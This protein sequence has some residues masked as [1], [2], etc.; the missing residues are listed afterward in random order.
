MNDAPSIAARLRTIAQTA[1]NSHLTAEADELYRL[2]F[3]VETEIR[4]LSRMAREASLADIH[5]VQKDFK[6][7]GEL[8]VR[9]EDDVLQ[10]ILAIEALDFEV[11]RRV[12]DHARETNPFDA[13]AA[14]WRGHLHFL[15]R[16]FP[17]ALADYLEAQWLG[18]PDSADRAGLRH[19]RAVR[20]LLNLDA[21]KVRQAAEAAH[22]RLSQKARECDAAFPSAERLN[23]IV[24][25]IIGRGGAGGTAGTIE[26]ARR[27]RALSAFDALD[28]RSLFGIAMLAQARH[29]KSGERIY[30]TGEAAPSFFLVAEGRIA[31]G[32]DTPVGDQPLGEAAAGDFFGASEAF[33]Q[34][35]RRCDATAAQESV[36]YSFYADGFFDAEEAAPLVAPLRRYLSRHLRFLNDLLKSFFNP[37]E[38]AGPIA[39]PAKA[40]DA[41]I[42]T[43]EKAELL[44][45]GGLAPQDLALFSSFCS[46]KTYGGNDVIFREGDPGD[47][48][49]VV[50]R[51]QVRI[52]RRIPGA[53]VEA[54]AILDSGAIFGEM[55]IFDP[56]AP[57]RSADAVAHTDCALLV[58]ERNI[59]ETLE[60]TDPESGAELS[61][62]L[63]RI[64]AQRILETTDRLI[65]WRILAGRF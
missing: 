10:G 12:L 64:A 25:K 34:V 6:T 28:D 65:Q 2:A 7:A 5:R 45:R 43:S 55:A 42:P 54:L 35:D 49:Y 4:R 32:R 9:A 11:A 41:S 31:V 26:R 17:E 50:A 60:A 3:E 56:E 57:G 21:A 27:L 46:E 39:D 14:S 48:L 53:G 44:A 36:V 8:A 59:L 20:A 47:V 40:V 13:R 33:L 30:A 51:G 29:A 37:N 18:L 15:Q 63:C 62:L 16:R 38:P 23:D 58:L 52:Q 1:E 61:A 22:M 19:L 24:K